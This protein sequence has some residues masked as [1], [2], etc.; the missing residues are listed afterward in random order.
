MSEL[1]SS[2]RT[3]NPFIDEVLKKALPNQMPVNVNMT[4]E[5]THLPVNLANTLVFNT[6]S[7]K[8]G[9]DGG[10][11]VGM[12]IRTWLQSVFQEKILE[13]GRFSKIVIIIG[14]D[15]PLHDKRAV[16]A[17]GMKNML[18]DL[19][20]ENFPVEIY[21]YNKATQEELF[22]GIEHIIARRGGENMTARQKTILKNLCLNGGY[23]PNRLRGMLAAYTETI[24][25]QSDDDAVWLENF[26]KI[27]SISAKENDWLYTQLENINEKTAEII[28]QPLIRPYLNMIGRTAHE[29]KNIENISAYNAT[30]RSSKNKALEQHLDTRKPAKFS[31]SHDGIEMPKQ[32]VDRKVAAIFG[33]ASGIPDI[34]AFYPAWDAINGS[35]ADYAFGAFPVGLS[36]PFTVAKMNHPSPFAMMIDSTN[37]QIANVGWMGI[38]TSFGSDN[39][40]LKAANNRLRC[41]DYMLT[42]LKGVIFAESGVRITH[43]KSLVGDRPG[44][45]HDWA[46]EGFSDIWVDAVKKL[47]CQ[48][49]NGGFEIVDNSK[50]L[51]NKTLSQESTQIVFEQAQKMYLK[52]NSKLDNIDR[53]TSEHMERLIS[54]KQYFED[55]E[56]FGFSRSHLNYESFH[57]N[58]QQAF[59]EQFVYFKDFLIVQEELLRT[60]FDLRKQGQM[61]AYK[62]KIN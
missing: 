26:V 7:Y 58:L 36:K 47:L 55:K 22:R 28:Q 38:D 60:A 19:N 57:Y 49:V 8:R 53:I 31:L 21:L 16:N 10:G 39:K 51:M 20:L 27:H 41:E 42:L 25:M 61:P 14:D 17:E 13:D 54:F 50:Q 12:T 24:M 46:S 62:L 32:Y 9:G 29:L 45:L 43:T 6:I 40:I 44:F 52:I 37:P 15:T 56:T 59:R 35:Q 33:N 4:F 34:N 3:K 23:L 18:H 1:Y 11:D 5:P 2:E 48:K 30:S